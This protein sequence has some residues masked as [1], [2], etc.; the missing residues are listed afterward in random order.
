MHLCLMISGQCLRR[1]R[2]ALRLP[3]RPSPISAALEPEAAEAAE[4]GPARA[5]TQPPAALLSL[6]PANVVKVRAQLLGLVEAY[7]TPG[8]PAAGGGS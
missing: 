6:T 2:R 5:P 3:R 7:A 4:G 8:A 1:A